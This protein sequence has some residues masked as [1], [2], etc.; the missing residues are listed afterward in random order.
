MGV[1]WKAC[2]RSHLPSRLPL[3]KPSTIAWAVGLKPFK[4]VLR[5]TVHQPGN[6]YIQDELNPSLQV[7][8]ATLSTGPVG[9]G[10]KINM[11]DMTLLRPCMMANGT[12]L[13]PSKAAT[14][15]EVSYTPA[16][17]H[18]EVWSTYSRTRSQGALL[19]HY[20]LAAAMTADYTL[21]PFM[22]NLVPG[23]QWRVAKFDTTWSLTELIFNSSSSLTLPSN[24]PQIARNFFGWNLVA[25][26][27]QQSNGWVLLGEVDKYVGLSWRRLWSVDASSASDLKVTVGGRL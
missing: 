5:T 21:Q 14:A 23:S 11:T 15:I 8:V 24:S 18:G 10:D 6:Y 9:I 19:A 1:F 17:P 20:V 4:D 16:A 26:L 13:A 2:F 25:L 27:P 22:L 7:V 3:G 12:I